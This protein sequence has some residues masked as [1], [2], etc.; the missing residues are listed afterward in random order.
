MTYSQI[1]TALISVGDGLAYSQVVKMTDTVQEDDTVL[2]Y[3]EG[4]IEK[5]RAEAAALKKESPND[6][7]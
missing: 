2:L 7:E 4:L 3:L 5:A 6:G 1:A